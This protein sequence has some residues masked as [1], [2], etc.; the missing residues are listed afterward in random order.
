[1]SNKK[2][3]EITPYR[4]ES[5]EIVKRIEHP[6]GEEKIS[7]PSEHKDEHEHYTDTTYD[8]NEYHQPEYHHHEYHQEEKKPKTILPIFAGLTTLGIIGYFGLNYLQTD[9]QTE[10][11]NTV[12][13]GIAD[14]NSSAVKG[15]KEELISYYVNKALEVKRNK[16]QAVEETTEPIKKVIETAPIEKQEVVEKEREKIAEEIKELPVVVE[17]E[18]E[19]K[20]TEEIKEAP[21]VIEKEK[22]KKITEEVKE[23]PV[24]IK[25]EKVVIAEKQEE[26]K[27]Q[28]VEKIEEKPV[29]KTVKKDKKIKI[30]YEKIKP[31]V[32]TV[33][34]GDTLASIAERFYGNSMDFKRIIRANSSIRSSRSSLHLDQKVIIPRKDGKK[35]RRFVTV[36][37]GDTLA[38]ISKAIYG[39]TDRISTIV[40]ANYKIKS[41]RSLLRLGQKVY[42]PRL[43]FFK[44]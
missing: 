36:E 24:V 43:E 42:I 15:T 4:E 37:K 7:S 1:M 14:T 19:E 13:A 6:E 40:R 5:S 21:I 39:D 31:R 38:S 9:T 25:K 27:E 41:K 44:K 32:V 20:V 34:S 28:K 3:S 17:K 29:V 35:R 10:T 23:V 8:N 33:K 16:P 30:F 26:T 2:N 22:E 18:K 12:V 11:K